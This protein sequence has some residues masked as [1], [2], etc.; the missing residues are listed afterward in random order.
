MGYENIKNL[1]LSFWSRYAVSWIAKALAAY[2][3]YDAA[4]AQSTGAQ[5]ALSI[6]TLAVVIADA[7]HAKATANQT[8]TKAV[9]KALGS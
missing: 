6:S 4:T 8:A 9:D 7:I 1:L 2:L 3:G 5:V